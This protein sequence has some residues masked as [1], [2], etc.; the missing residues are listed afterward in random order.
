MESRPDRPA[1]PTDPGPAPATTLPAPIARRL[2]H[3][4]LPARSFRDV[5][6]RPGRRPTRL[7]L[8]IELTDGRL[9][10]ARL[11]HRDGVAERM[12]TWLPRLDARHFPRL[13]DAA[14]R[15]SLEEWREGSPAPA[16]DTGVVAVA[17]AMLGALHALVEPERLPVEDPR[18]QAW[19]R[20]L[21]ECIERLHRAGHLPQADRVRRRLA[22][23]PPTQAL[24]G[25]THGDLC[26]E[27]LVVCP[28]PAGDG[29]LCCI[30]NC[31]VAPGFL[32]A[33]LAR[34]ILR[35]PLTAGEREGF[36]APHD[37]RAGGTGYAEHAD[38]WQL[39]AALRSADWRLREGCDGLE[40]A[41]AEVHRQVG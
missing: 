18:R 8:R 32:E 9:L 2:Q 10:K 35:W 38:H 31:S 39:A 28:P 19:T 3:L 11:L 34:S 6:A 24:W 25:L 33:D 17:G 36:L 14:D 27:N 1:R 23:D 16:G 37:L 5:T 7:T 20:R 15:V 13:V 4:G 41:L 30:D 22:A 29:G 12:R 21:H 26:L 40:F